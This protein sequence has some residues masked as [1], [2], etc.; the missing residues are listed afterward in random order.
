MY[1]ELEQ[2]IRDQVE[3]LHASIDLL[4]G[5]LIDLSKYEKNDPLT[6]IFSI[7]EKTENEFNKEI[8]ELQNNINNYIKDYKIKYAASKTKNFSYQHLNISPILGIDLG[9]SNSTVGYYRLNSRKRGEM[10]I[11]ANL[12]GFKSIPSVVCIVDNK[13]SVGKEAIKLSHKNPKN[14]IYDSKRMLG[15]KFN[16]PIIQKYRKNWAFDIIPSETGG[17]LIKVGDKKYK[18]YEI[19]GMILT[20][21][22]NLANSQLNIQTNQAIIT[23]PANFTNEQIEDTKRAAK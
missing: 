23:V 14:F 7:L 21:L 18:P 11:V 8:K 2:L 6:K 3:Y 17:I 4:N 1:S 20:E 15:K 5:I 13:I 9:T 19:S 22:M 10:D 12:E 16:D